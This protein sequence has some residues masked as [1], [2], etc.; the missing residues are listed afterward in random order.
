MSKKGKTNNERS[1]KSFSFILKSD[2]S[3]LKTGYTDESACLL[4]QLK[5]NKFPYYGD[6]LSGKNFYGIN[7]E[8]GLSKKI[9]Y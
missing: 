5:R 3:H 8:N 6:R 1:R 2:H 4:K 9:T 7:I